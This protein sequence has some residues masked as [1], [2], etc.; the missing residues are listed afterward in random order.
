MDG[1]ALKRLTPEVSVIITSRERREALLATLRALVVQ[2]VA[3]VRLRGAGGGRR[4]DG[5][6]VRRGRVPRCPLRPARAAAREQRG[7]AA[8]RNTAIREAR[9]RVLIFLSDDLLV[10]HGFVA[11]H[12]AALERHPGAWVVGGFRQL[13]SLRETPFGRYLD[14]LEECFTEARKQAPVGPDVWEL[15]GPPRAT[16]RCRAPT[17][18]GW[19]RSTSAS[20]RPAR[21]RTSPSAPA[22]AGI[23]FLYDA[24][25]DCLHND[26]AGDL[27]RCCRASA[28]APTT[29]RCSAPSTAERHGDSPFARAN[30]PL[31][32]R[33]AG[34]RLARRRRAKWLLSRDPML[35]LPGSSRAAAGARAARPSRSCAASTAGSS[36]STR[37]A[38]GATGCRRWRGG[39]PR[40]TPA[41][42]VVIPAFNHARFLPARRSRAC[43][44][45]R[46][47]RARSSSSTTGRPTS[48]TAGARALPRAGSASL[49]QANRGVSAARNAGRRAVAAASC[50]RSWTRTTCGCRASWKRRP[51]GSPATRDLGLV[52]CG[53]EEIDAEGREL[54]VRA[55]R[56]RRTGGGGDDALPA[57]RDPG[58]RQRRGRAARASSTE[59]G[60]FDESLVHLRRL[61]PAPPHRAAPRGRLRA[62]SALV[63]YRVHGANMHADVARTAREMLPAYA[64]GVRRGRRPCG[65][66]RRRAYG[67]LHAM[68]A[69]SFHAQGRS[70][71]ALAPRPARPRHT[72]RRR[73]GRGCSATRCGACGGSA[74]HERGALRVLSGPRRASR[75]TQVRPYLRALAA[76]GHRMHL[77]TFETA[78]RDAAEPRRLLGQALAAQGIAWHA[79]RY[80]RWPSLPATLYD[81]ARGVLARLPP[82]AAARDRAR[83][84]RART[85]VP[86]SRCR[87]RALL[88]CRS[89]STCAACCP[90]STRTRALAARRSQVPAGARPW[91]AS[92]S[93]A[94]QALVVL[95]ETCARTSRPRRPARARAMPR[96]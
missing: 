39:A 61:G 63:R 93:A 41:V 51:R 9:G 43:W 70:R 42:S 49:R 1:S 46:S 59:V 6:Y 12:L 34:V 68:L 44:P 56:N 38:A 25:I 54:G 2:T 76:R 3:A 37:S 50:S 87:L 18:N 19:G 48:T 94:R 15:P 80:H 35:A 75:A 64:Q 74:P 10:P 45:R 95:T 90:T 4:L 11:A 83:C 82:G 58:R 78:R 69:G 62:A 31:A 91:S 16:S 96:T 67:G 13:P 8:G 81:I 47:R 77:L 84:T 17:S 88:G 5:R 92:S 30:G 26:Q 73:P 52:H 20:A 29:P 55:G 7:V 57:R 24:S 21:T 28:G 66:L 86:P 32:P 60:G 36:G 85:W 72:T 23:R 40:V 65:P 22:R 71:S 33:R 53:V 14:D 89:C 27:V 79:L